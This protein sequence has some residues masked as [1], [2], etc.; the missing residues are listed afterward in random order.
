MTADGE[1][2]EPDYTEED[3]TAIRAMATERLERRR[4][5]QAYADLMVSERMRQQDIEGYTAEHDA[6]HEQHEW[7]GLMAMYASAG[8]WTKAG[9]LAIA[10]DEAGQ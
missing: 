10:A 1:T 7:V 3:M 8:D 2:R 5:H 9:A 6:Q 4:K